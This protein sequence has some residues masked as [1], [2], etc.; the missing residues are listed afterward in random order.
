MR[1]DIRWII[2]EFLR[3]GPKTS[4]KIFQYL[5]NESDKLKNKVKNCKGK[6]NGT[7]KRKLNKPALYYHLWQLEDIGIIQL[8]VF[9]PS[10]HGRALEKVW[11][12]NIGKVTINLK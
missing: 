11:K 5:I 4:D 8:D 7:I 10:E 3:S 2:V 6:C 12:L 1:C 9:K